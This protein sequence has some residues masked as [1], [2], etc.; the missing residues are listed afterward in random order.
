M[1]GTQ[2][3]ATTSLGA[4]T[5]PDAGN[6]SEIVISDFQF[7]G[8]TEFAVDQPVRITNEDAVTHTW[9]SD[10]GVF[11]SGELSPGDTFEFTFQEP[12][13]YTFFCSI[14]P[15]SMTGSITVEG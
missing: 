11:D 9:T 8:E 7:M 13:E 2:P 4:S 14:H 3:A 5:T 10:D 15:A 1:A 12:G 6:D